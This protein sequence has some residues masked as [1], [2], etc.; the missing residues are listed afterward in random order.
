MRPGLLGSEMYWLGSASPK[1][2]KNVLRDALERLVRDGQLSRHGARRYRKTSG[3]KVF[4]GTLTVTR[5]GYGFVMVEGDR[6]DV[7]VRG[8][9]LDNA[10]HRDRVRIEIFK[11]RDGR[12]EGRVLSVLERGTQ[13][14]G[15]CSSGW[16][17]WL[18]RTQR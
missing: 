16:E 14:C 2:E 17:A 8:I 5:Q 7:F 11:G 4:T 10:M 3:E 18:D 12:D 9:H 15:R 6:A 1:G 13:T